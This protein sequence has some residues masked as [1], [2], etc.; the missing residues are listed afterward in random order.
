MQPPVHFRSRPTGKQCVSG[1]RFEAAVAPGI[2]RTGR[3]NSTRAPPL[4]LLRERFFSLFLALVPP[5]PSSLCPR[6]CTHLLLYLVAALSNLV[7]VLLDEAVLA[8][9]LLLAPPHGFLQLEVV[10]LGVERVYADSRLLV[11]K[12]GFL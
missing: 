7:L 10:R 6:L 9:Q 11:L 1:V 3:A 5:P 4:N 12:V 2:L 8:I